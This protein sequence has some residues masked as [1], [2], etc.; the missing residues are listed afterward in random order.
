MARQIGIRTIVI[1][2]KINEV[3]AGL[4]KRIPSDP[5]DIW[6]DCL[7]DF[8]KIGPR[9][10]VSVIGTKGKSKSLATYPNIP[11]PIRIHMSKMLRLMLNEPTSIK[12]KISGNNI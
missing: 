3:D 5:P 7:R 9:I 10:T 4:R 2:I 11:K 12:T 6:S 8:S 1:A